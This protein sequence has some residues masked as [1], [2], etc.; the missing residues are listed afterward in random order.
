MGVSG[1]SL[2]INWDALEGATQ[3]YAV[4]D[5]F[6]QDSKNKSQIFDMEVRILA[7]AGT[8]AQPHVNCARPTRPALGS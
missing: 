8:Y 7:V 1:K 4:S 5:I 2:N 3:K 6:K